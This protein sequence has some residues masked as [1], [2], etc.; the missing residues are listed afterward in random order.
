MKDNE[1]IDELDELLKSFGDEPDE[2]IEFIS[3]EDF[4]NCIAESEKKLDDEY[5][6]IDQIKAE[7]F[8][9][10]MNEKIIYI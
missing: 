2:R 4:L 8:K 7:S 5:F 6:K 1:L 9:D 10:A 3:H